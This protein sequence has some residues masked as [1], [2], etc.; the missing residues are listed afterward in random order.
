MK[1]FV[2][3]IVA[4]IF[5]ASF[6]LTRDEA[7]KT[8]VTSQVGFVESCDKINT[9]PAITSGTKFK[10]LDGK[11]EVILEA[12]RGPVLIN[13][14]GSWC[15]PCKL[16][17][18]FLVALAQTKKVAIVGINIDEPDMETP[19]DFVVHTGITWPNLFDDD[20]RSNGTFGFGVPVTWFIDASGKVTYR[21]IGVIASQEILFA[22]V[23]KY[24]G[25]KV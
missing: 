20:G 5:L 14:W 13:V 9:D 18:P 17:M 24:L 8:T 2:A 15:P 11:S 3:A 23:E 10:C 4:V 22:E 25:I 12:I 16:E 21:H 7:A 19:R 1:Y 6:G